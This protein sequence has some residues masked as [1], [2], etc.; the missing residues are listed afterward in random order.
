MTGFQRG[1]VT[2]AVCPQIAKRAQRPGTGMAQGGAVV[3][4]RRQLQPLIGDGQ[5]QLQRRAT[6]RDLGILL[7]SGDVIMDGLGRV[8]V[9][10]QMMQTVSSALGKVAHRG[11]SD[12]LGH[13]KGPFAMKC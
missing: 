7:Q 2:G 9:A 8:G 1:S 13:G 10:A 12:H 5:S 11:Q 4:I 6:A 3:G